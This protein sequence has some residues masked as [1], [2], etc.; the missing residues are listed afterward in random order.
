MALLL[1]CQAPFII[2]PQMLPAPLPQVESK[3]GPEDIVPDV[4]HIKFKKG[5]IDDLQASGGKLLTVG[6]IKSPTLSKSLGDKTQIRPL[7]ETVG[8]MP[9]KVSPSSPLKNYYKVALN[10]QNPDIGSSVLMN[11]ERAKPTIA[12]LSGLQKSLN[13]KDPDLS[14]IE[15]VKPVFALK[16]HESFQF[17]WGRFFPNQWGVD[18]KGQPVR[19][20]GQDGR[21]ANISG[22]SGADA[23]MIDK[24]NAAWDYATGE[25]TRV[26]IIDSGVKG[27]HVDL[28]ETIEGEGYDF[29]NR[30]VTHA[31][32]SEDNYGHGSHV[33]GI[34]SGR[35][36]GITG[37]S[38]AKIWNMA[39]INGAGFTSDELVAEAILY[40]KQK[41]DQSNR[42]VVMNM[43]LGGPWPSDL[44]RDAIKE[45]EQNP[46][47]VIVASAGNAGR[48]GE[49]YP[50]AYTRLGGIAASDSSD[51]PAWFTSFG[52]FVGVS[53]PGRGIY[54]T[55]PRGSVLFDSLSDYVVWLEGM[56]YA[57]MDGTSMAAPFVAGQA[58]LLLGLPGMTGERVENIIKMTA[59]FG[60]GSKTLSLEERKKYYGERGGRINILR[61]LRRASGKDLYVVFVPHL[62]RPK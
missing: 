3:I 32:N 10:N 9:L 27:K 49:N 23:H 41:A 43:S 8:D 37:I 45:A 29:L 40:T 13:T 28:N 4:L 31:G 30:H 35:G 18:N 58:S 61:S 47:I 51:N 42:K 14:K 24:N 59:D 17:P 33:A 2:A 12:I 21:P 55:I 56:P 22:I 34:V 46:F 6:D 44:I 20:R 15:Q 16:A 48:E 5:Y 11:S 50:A 62:E 36:I 52:N 54:S 53:A 57:P 39:I 1:L 38:K 60:V 26:A 7:F 19:M 25:E